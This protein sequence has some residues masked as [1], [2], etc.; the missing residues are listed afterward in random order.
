MES[1]IPCSHGGRALVV[2]ETKEVENLEKNSKDQDKAERQRPRN[3]IRL[4]VD[5]R[6]LDQGTKYT[7]RGVV[8]LLKGV[9]DKDDGED[10]TIP[11]ATKTI[12]DL[13]QVGVKFSL[14]EQ[15]FLHSESSMAVRR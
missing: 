4:W 9:G 14:F 10:G 13:P 2:K 3:F 6:V 15:N 1:R 11:E 8:S 12:R 7:I 5:A